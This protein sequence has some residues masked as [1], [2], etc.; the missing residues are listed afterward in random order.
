MTE[1]I[2]SFKDL[3]TWQAAQDLAVGI[4]MVTKNFPDDEK[5][6]LT[7]QIRRAVV[8]VGSNI[9]E[10][11]SRK[12]SKEKVQF[13]HIAKGSLTEVES[14]IDLAKRIG[15]VNELN[16]Q[17]ICLKCDETSRLLTGLIRSVPIR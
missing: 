5:F 11:F 7:N 15:Y 2:K 8:S 4:Y 16:Y 3:N 12:S 14:Q 17:S 1:Q 13:Y 10:G 6:G 9:A